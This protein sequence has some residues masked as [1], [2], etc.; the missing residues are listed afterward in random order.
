MPFTG[1]CYRCDKIGHRAS[2]CPSRPAAAAHVAASLEIVPYEDP[3]GEIAFA[4]LHVAMASG[5]VSNCDLLLDSACS[6]HMICHRHLFTDFV[7]ATTG[8]VAVGGGGVLGVAGNGIVR[9]KV[10]T[11]NRACGYFVAAITAMYVPDMGVNLLSMGTLL[12]GG[13]TIAPSGSSGTVRLAKGDVGFDNVLRNGVLHVPVLTPLNNVFP[14]AALAAGANVQA[15]AQCAFTA[16]VGTEVAHLTN[17]VPVNRLLLWHRRLAHTNVA[18]I[19]K[20]AA[21]N[22]MLGLDIGAY[23]SLETPCVACLKGKMP[24]GTFDSRSSALAEPAVASPGTP[25]KTVTFEMPTTSDLLELMCMDVRGPSSTRSIAGSQY[26]MEALDVHSRKAFTIHFRTRDVVPDL[27]KGLVHKVEQQTKRSVKEIRLDGAGEHKTTA[28]LAWAASRGTNLGFTAPRDSEQNGLV[29]R[30]NRTLGDAERTMLAGGGMPPYCWAEAQQYATYIYN[31]RPHSFTGFA[32]N[33]LWYGKVPDVSGVRTFGCIVW[34]HL[35]KEDRKNKASARAYR[36]RLLGYEAGAKVYRVL[37]DT[38]AVK[39]TTRCVFDERMLHVLHGPAVV[40]E[41]DEDDQNIS[42]LPYNGTRT[43]S[44]SGAPDDA[45][46]AGAPAAGAATTEDTDAAGATTAD[47]PDI[48]ADSAADDIPPPLDDVSAEL[49]EAAAAGAAS[50]GATDSASVGAGRRGLRARHPVMRLSTSETGQWVDCPSS[51]NSAIGSLL[52][53]GDPWRN[54]PIITDF[55]MSAVACLIPHTDE[56]W[57]NNLHAVEDIALHAGVFLAEALK[58]VLAT[59]VPTPTCHRT[60]AN[61]PVYGDLWNSAMDEEFNSL[62]EKQ[63]F[64]LVPR[65][66]AGSTPVARSALVFK[67]K[68]TSTGS[69]DKFK[70]RLCY[71]GH[72]HRGHG[73]DVSAPVARLTTLRMLVALVAANDWD[74]RQVDV[75]TAFLNGSLPNPR[76]M[77]Q[78]PWCVDKEHADWIWELLKALY[79]MPEAARIWNQL[80]TKVLLE[81]GFVQSSSDDCLY[82]RYNPDGSVDLFALV[83]V[84]DFIVTGPGCPEGLLKSMK[85]A[86]WELTDLGEAKWILGM[87]VERNR[88]TRCIKLHQQKYAMDVLKRFGYAECKSVSTP[89]ERLLPPLPEDETPTDVE[90]YQSLVGALL[91]LANGTRPDIALAVGVLSRYSARPGPAHHNAA[92]R[93]LCYLSGTIEL[94]LV[95]GS[96]PE[97]DSLMGYA[98]ADYAGDHAD[99]KSCSGSIFFHRGGPVS[100]RSVKQKCVALSTAESEYIALCLSVQEAVWLRRVMADMGS[101]QFGATLVYTGNQAAEVMAG[102]GVSAHSRTKHIA[103]RFHYVRE[104]V[105]AKTVFVKWITTQKMLADLLTKPLTLEIFRRLVQLC[106]H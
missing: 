47:V 71:G 104:Q 77:H 16:T 103:V 101:E 88:I 38:G 13:W 3:Y 62:V 20:A 63:V 44:A 5:G 1:S 79:G 40:D 98:D 59:D 70:V 36:G 34:A 83:Y 90:M 6:S 39:R 9:L 92:T 50:V 14:P 87:A 68:S 32:P 105:A 58:G 54:S 24:R 10:A 17:A 97:H 33:Q 65:S 82:M 23:R 57:L 100:W 80:V 60:A 96:M 28:F 51:A 52:P 75:K 8:A 73:E 64:R 91:Y 93:V 26:S 42:V 102:R 66:A 15:T 78:P 53:A 11:A 106:M 7:P 95:F 4:A 29:E 2:E 61:H 30:F 43:V 21:D 35:P 27:I 76:Y 19:I 67:V 69:V 72:I 25:V 99:R 84:D 45:I 85:A 37:S 56:D 94:G 74:M 31:C 12:D 18:T 55:A 49:D 81:A 41:Y 86:G 46:V 22:T 48:A 89:C